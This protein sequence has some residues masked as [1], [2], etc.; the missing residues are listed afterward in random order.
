MTNFII[1]KTTAKGQ[2][3]IYLVNDGESIL[4]FSQPLRKGVSNFY[5]NGVEFNKA[6][7]FAK[8][9]ND[10]AII[11]TME[12]I[13]AYVPYI[14]KE[15]EVVVF[16]KRENKKDWRLNKAFSRSKSKQQKLKLIQEVA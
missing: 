14:Q 11:R 8:A 10:T 12:K 2:M 9:N 6:I 5:K 13:I 15:F 4:L 3:S 16:N 7:N 1:S